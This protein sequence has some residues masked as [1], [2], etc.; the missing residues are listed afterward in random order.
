ME[1]TGSIGSPPPGVE[2]YPSKYYVHPLDSAQRVGDTFI[3]GAFPRSV[4]L[5]VG[6]SPSAG[7]PFGVAYPNPFNESAFVGMPEGCGEKV[8][9]VLTDVAGN[10]VRRQECDVRAGSLEIRRDCLPAAAY[11]L[12]ISGRDGILC[13]GKIIIR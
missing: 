1:S 10:T 13:R 7:S 11:L 9:L 2:S 12:L 6:I 4:G 8:T 3:R 5:G